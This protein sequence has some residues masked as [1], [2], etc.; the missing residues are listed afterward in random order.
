M[1]RLLF[2]VITIGV[3]LSSCV[4]STHSQS[5]HK[6]Q[7]VTS[8]A[9]TITLIFGGDLMG[10][11]PQIQAA[12]L[13]STDGYDYK[14]GFRYLFH[15]IKSAHFAVANLEVTLAGPP[16]SG[17]P[18]FSSPD[19]YAFNM[20]ELGFDLLVTANNHSQDGGKKGLIRTLQVLDSFKLPH[21]GTF[22]DTSEFQNNYPFITEIKG[23]KV[24]I[25]NYTYGTNGLIVQSPTMVNIIDSTYILEAI[26][27]AK[28]QGAQIII[29]V[30][31]WGNEY[32]R[33]ESNYQEYWAQFL[34]DNGADAIIGMHPHVVQPIKYILS[35][36]GKKVPVA[37]SLGNFVSNQRERY[38]DGGILARLKVVRKDHDIHILGIDYKPFWVHKL[39]PHEIYA[40][41]ERR[42][43]YLIPP[44][45]M[46]VLKDTYHA[47][48]LEFFQD[49]R[50]LLKDIPE[51]D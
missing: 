31:H 19:D 27:K 34:A 11:G 44:K 1:Q 20:K 26:K 7:K 51:W 47:Q 38:K 5:A 17:Y 2:T 8:N 23:I 21:T 37:Y 46:D 35:N 25:L 39:L 40:P 48:A 6:N 14:P 42:G 10:H 50:E 9:D 15:D 16:Y 3:S 18:Q 32:Q 41:F 24:A 45:N 13:D 12:K 4:Q 33:R 30:M 36:N 29:P 28:S 22:K 49:T 43:Y